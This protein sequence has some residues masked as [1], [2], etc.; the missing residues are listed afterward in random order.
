MSNETLF[1]SVRYIRF[2]IV[3][4]F[5]LQWIWA[6]ETGSWEQIKTASDTVHIAVLLL[7]LSQF[8]LK[9]FTRFIYCVLFLFSFYCS[10]NCLSFISFVPRWLGENE[11]AHSHTRTQARHA[12]S[13]KR[14]RCN[15]LSSL[16]SVVPHRNICAHY[17]L[18]WNA[19]IGRNCQE[20]YGILYALAALTLGFCL[21]RLPRL[22]T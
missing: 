8:I 2:I 16:I 17:N 6:N 12:Q 5:M 14:F 21:H 9:M 15:L 1:I 3:Q 4:F 13:E 19:Y 11:R 22:C 18:Q 20:F 7:R 10:S